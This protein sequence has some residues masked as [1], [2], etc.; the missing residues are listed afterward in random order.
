MIKLLM[1]KSY[2][3]E[4]T[5]P[6]QQTV[7]IE[8]APQPKKK[9]TAQEQNKK[10]AKNIKQEVPKKKEEIKIQP[11]TYQKQVG[12]I[13]LELQLQR[14]DTESE[15]ARD[16]QLRLKQL[17]EEKAK[18]DARKQAEIDK[19]MKFSQHQEPVQ[20]QLYLSIKSIR[21][22]C[23]NHDGTLNKILHQENE[24]SRLGLN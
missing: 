3:L 11:S 7:A 20:A 13:T 23:L 18:E 12:F 14:G 17:E 15:L 21:N 24:K 2:K 10:G 1:S 6:L 4:I 5:I 8:E 19:Y 16:Y 22:L 9:Q